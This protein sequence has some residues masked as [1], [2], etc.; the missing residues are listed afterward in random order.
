MLTALFIYKLNVSKCDLCT[1]TLY[2][3]K[4]NINVKR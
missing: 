4:P 1:I 3:E 2:T